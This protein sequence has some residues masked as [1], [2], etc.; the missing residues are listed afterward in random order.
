VVPSS[1][2]PVF[3]SV[4]VFGTDPIAASNFFKSDRMSSSNLGYLAYACCLES[5]C[6]LVATVLVVWVSVR[7]II[8][9]LLF[10]RCVSLV[11]TVSAVALPEK[12]AELG[13]P[14]TG[15]W[16]V[17][18]DFWDGPLP[19][20]GSGVSEAPIAVISFLKVVSITV[21]W[22]GLASTGVTSLVAPVLFPVH[23]PDIAGLRG[24][25]SPLVVSLSATAYLTN[26][27]VWLILRLPCISAGCSPIRNLGTCP[28]AAH[29][30]GNLPTPNL[31]TS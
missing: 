26:P 22:Y 17:D 3:T 12:G 5:D 24:S 21:V 31:R 8:P 4:L 29:A 23:E 1:F 18:D 13:A 10:F 27:K 9:I 30:T 6:L 28:L 14:F 16:L 11:M 20:V 2:A 25:I 19:T 7:T 15:V